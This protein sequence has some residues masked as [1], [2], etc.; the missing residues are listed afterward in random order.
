MELSHYGYSTEKNAEL[1]KFT[2]EGPK[3][4]IQKLIVYAPMQ[5]LDVYNLG[6]GDYDENTGLVND[7]II[8]N[9]SDSQKI[10]ATVA[11]T[12]YVFTSKHPSAW[13]Y[14]TG[15]SAARTRLYRIG[16][17]N[18]LGQIEKDFDVFALRE[19]IWE[20]FKKGAN[21]EAFLVKRKF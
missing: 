20:K 9:N 5:E 11:S 1:F 8:T 18:Y 2:S 16:I 3:G 13:V 19:D 12:L 14:A 21:Y 15:S 10:L 7:L 4:Q 6:F 17:N